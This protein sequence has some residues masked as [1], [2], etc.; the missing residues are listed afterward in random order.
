MRVAMVSVMLMA[1][2]TPKPAR[3][4]EPV[5]PPP[6][7]A[8]AQ[9]A[10]VVPDVTDTVAALRVFIDRVNVQG[11]ALSYGPLR[12][13]VP[14]TSLPASIK[15]ETNVVEWHGNHV[16]TAWRTGSALCSDCEGY[17]IDWVDLYKQSVARF[18]VN[19]VLPRAKSGPAD[20]A[21]RAILAQ[22]LELDAEPCRCGT[23]AVPDDTAKWSMPTGDA[24]EKK[25]CIAAEQSSAPFR[26]KR[27]AVVVE[28]TLN[29]SRAEVEVQLMLRGAAWQRFL[30]ANS[31]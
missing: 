20:D 6:P 13:D 19:T 25:D 24:L 27:G 18:V 1:C 5:Q 21:C 9:P 14:A 28:G 29:V 30:E 17:H 23:S 7:T 3:P 26:I 12:L 4:R 16:G 8:P 11:G 15:L 22:P 2:G 10:K 31:K